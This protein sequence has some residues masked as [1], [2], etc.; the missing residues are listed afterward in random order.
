M[1]SLVQWSLSVIGLVG[2]NVAELR[3]QCQLGTLS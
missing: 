3:Y 1:V 2:L